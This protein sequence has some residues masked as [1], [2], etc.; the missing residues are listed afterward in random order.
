MDEIGIKN[1]VV[2]YVSTF[3]YKGFI[4]LLCEIAKPHTKA[5]TVCDTDHP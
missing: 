4:Y 2:V 1:L 5:I 3:S